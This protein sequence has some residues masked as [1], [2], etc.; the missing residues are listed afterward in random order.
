MLNF[1]SIN[2]LFPGIKF[3][4]V[5]KGMLAK[6]IALVIDNIIVKIIII[7]EEYASMFLNAKLFKESIYPNDLE[8][9]AYVVDIVD[10]NDHV[11][12]LIC[13]EMLYSILLS[14]PSIF[15][16][17]RRYKYY[18]SL[19]EGWHYINGEFVIPGV[20]E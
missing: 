8:K 3:D 9:E 11:E 16:L 19:A 14:E 5:E 1:N 2:W 6:S 20:K 15:L 10:Q 13:D 4:R 12:H 18:E 7:D 17:D